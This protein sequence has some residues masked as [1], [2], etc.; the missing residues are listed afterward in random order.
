MAHCPTISWP[1]DFMARRFYG[2]RLTRAFL[3]FL[4][5]Q[6]AGIVPVLIEP[7]DS[8]KNDS[9]KVDPQFAA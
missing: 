8:G 1:D 7:N 5:K 9:G 3:G 4:S 6:S 2:L